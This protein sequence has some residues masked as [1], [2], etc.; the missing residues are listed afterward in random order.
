MAPQ[1]HYPGTGRSPDHSHSCRGLQRVR[2]A[3]PTAASL[4]KSQQ[5][6]QENP[7]HSHR[8]PVPHGAI[9]DDLAILNLMGVAQA[10]QRSDKGAD[11]E[12]EMDTVDACNQEEEMAADIGGHHYALEVKLVP[13]EPLG[14]RE[15]AGPETLSR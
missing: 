2:Q 4:E 13:C 7:E 15:I 11:T 3:E 5:G 14:Q 12:Y 8:V 1:R 6:K 9:H 10:K